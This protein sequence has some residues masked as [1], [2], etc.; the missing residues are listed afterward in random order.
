MLPEGRC[1]RTRVPAVRVAGT[2]RGRRGQRADRP[3]QGT[4]RWVARHSDAQSPRSGRQREREPR[5]RSDGEHEGECTGPIAVRQAAAKI[6]HLDQDLDLLERI[7]E[8]HD[9]LVRRSF[10]DREEALDST[11]RRECHRDA[12][13]RVGRQPDDPSRLEDRDGLAL[14]GQ[15]IGDQPC[16]QDP[17]RRG[18][19]SRATRGCPARSRATSV[20]QPGSV[21]WARVSIASA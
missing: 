18:G 17:A 10:L 6:R 21:S 11:R 1:D 9:C 2:I 14:A 4:R 15:P 20:R 7:G 19:S 12:V 8:D 16:G 5:V 13:D 3:C